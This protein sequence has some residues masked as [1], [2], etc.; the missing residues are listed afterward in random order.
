ME[1][2]DAAISCPRTAL[3][4]INKYIQVP[5]LVRFLGDIIKSSEA[6]QLT[7]N[8]S[9]TPREEICTGLRC[10]I[11]A[12]GTSLNVQYIEQGVLGIDTKNNAV[13]SHAMLVNGGGGSSRQYVQLGANKSK[14]SGA[15]SISSIVPIHKSC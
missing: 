15:C 12:S 9:R 1:N 13:A 4:I 6:G 8:D 3:G 7:L 11:L 5:K 14:A 2:Y 10:D